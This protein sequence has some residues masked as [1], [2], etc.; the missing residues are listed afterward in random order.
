MKYAIVA[1][2]LGERYQ[3]MFDNLC[4]KN[5][6]NYAKKINADLIIVDRR[7]D[8]SQR[9][10]S[11]CVVWEK[12]IIP[13]MQELQGY[14]QVLM[15]DTDIIINIEKAPSIF[16]FVPIG[17][18]GVIESS[19]NPNPEIHKQ[20]VENMYKYWDTIGHKYTRNID[21]TSLYREYGFTD[22]PNESAYGGVVV[23]S[24]KIHAPIFRSA[25]DKYEDKGGVLNHEARPLSYEIVTS[26]AALWL[27]YR[28]NY[29]VSD[30]IFR[31]YRFILDNDMFSELAEKL[32]ENVRNYISYRLFER[33]VGEMYDNSYFLHFA[34]WHWMMDFAKPLLEKK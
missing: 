34:G 3:K 4:R 18:I 10:D 17:R 23:F 12:L 29:V 19:S 20:T 13:E 8:L 21:S 9:S 22:P 6:E 24:P 33:C 15:L 14:D 26:G 2:C 16:D 5:W 30:D 27:D 32:G 11:R 1:Q 28:F 25:Y 31:N 7:L